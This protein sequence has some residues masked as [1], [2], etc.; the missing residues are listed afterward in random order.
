M[1]TTSSTNLTGLLKGPRYQKDDIVVINRGGIDRK[2]HIYL[3]PYEQDISVH[4]DGSQMTWVYP[5]DYGLG[6]TSEGYVTE[7]QIKRKAGDDDDTM[8]FN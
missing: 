3:P 4:G 5:V 2:R 6:W 7:G 1:S 8:M